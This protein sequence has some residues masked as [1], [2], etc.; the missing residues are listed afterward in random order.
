M[1]S[2]PS[3]RADLTNAGAIWEDK[4]V[5]VGGNLVTSRSP[6]ALPDFCCEMMKLVGATGDRK[7]A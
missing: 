4:S 6:D 2:W 3:L 7:A 5:V 1:T